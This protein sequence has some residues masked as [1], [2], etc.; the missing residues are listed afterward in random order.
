MGIIL[1]LHQ[2]AL[3]LQ[4][5]H[6]GLAAFVAVHTLIFAAVFVDSAV[7][8]DDADNIQLV[9]H[10]DL[11]VIGVVGGGHLHRA[12]AEADLA[13]IVAHDR[14]LP[15]HDGQDAL[16]ANEMSELFVLRVDGHAGIAHH[17]LRT[18]G[19]DHQIAAAVGQGIADVPHMAGLLGIFHLRV[20]EGG[21][22]V[23]APV[24]DAGALIN[25]ALLIQV[26]K[27]LLHRPGAALVHGEPGAAPIAGSAHLLL[28]GDDPVAKPVFPVPDPLQK[29]LPAQVIAGQAFLA[30]C[31]L[32]LDLS[33]DA[34]MVRPGDPKGGIALHPLGAD[35][36][37]LQGAVHSMA[38]VQLSGNVG[39]GHDDGEGLFVRIH[40]GPEEA[41]LLPKL[42]K[43][44]L[45][46]R[47][48]IGLGQFLAIAHLI[49]LL[50]MFH[51]CF[52][53]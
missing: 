33:G 24:D 43:S 28:L 20:R 42:I 7:I 19:G 53:Q 35:Q 10:A 31:F 52:L 30:Q 13:V 15:V 8:G 48:I 3:L 9:A 12:G 11:K 2:I 4:I 47:R 45:R 16:F 26:D 38:H 49:F 23:G 5:A 39:R 41:A 40:P 50:C 32:H 37:I 17:G 21:G 22:A 44:A 29:L 34:R 46:R 25:I 18:G 27:D 1:H 51:L 36:D 14:D 6:D